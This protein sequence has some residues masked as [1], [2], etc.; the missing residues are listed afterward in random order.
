MGS[1]SVAREED[2]IHDAEDGRVHPDPESQGQNE[3]DRVSGSACE[4]TDRGSDVFQHDFSVPIPFLHP[5]ETP[6]APRKPKQ[7]YPVTFMS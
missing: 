6:A 7:C 4:T 2:P 5:I 1:T 3:G